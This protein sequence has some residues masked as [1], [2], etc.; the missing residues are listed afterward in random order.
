M[1]QDMAELSR[2]SVVVVI[3]VYNHPRTIR[4]MV[5]DVQ[6]HGLPLVLVDDG[7]GAV[8]AAVLR[9]LAEAHTGITLVR[10][11]TNQGK[12]GAMVAGLRKA[13]ALGYSHA[14]Q[15][16]ADGQHDTADIPRFVAT[17][18]QYPHAVV[19][20]CPVYDASVP[21]LRLYARYLT[22][23]AVWVNCLSLAIRDSM[24]GFRVYPL[25]SVMAVCDSARLGRRMDFDPEVLV[26]LHWQGVAMVNLQTR[27]IYPLNGV[28]HY[29]FW[30]DT[31]LL[32]RMHL[33]LFGG[34]LLRILRLPQLFK[35]S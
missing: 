7:S 30:R 27:V 24:C 3:P 23:V 2:F 21:R 13:F 34:L 22:H 33:R 11:D 12:G 20:G 25:D 35:L 28:S 31:S 4:A 6:S 32:A 26:R 14:L 19:T 16:D 8:C 5:A 10:L 9:D 17:A 18:S 15:I 29:Q 1:E